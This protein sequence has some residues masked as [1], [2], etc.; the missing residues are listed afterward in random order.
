MKVESLKKVMNEINV[1]IDLMEVLKKFQAKRFKEDDFDEEQFVTEALLVQQRSALVDFG[2][3]SN[4]EEF[5]SAQ[6][7]EQLKGTIGNGCLF[8]YLKD[9]D[10]F[11]YVVHDLDITTEEGNEALEIFE[12]IMGKVK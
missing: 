12:L 1:I 5:Y 6:S 2:N 4:Y 3:I 11:V 9:V 10:N 8:D 7:Q